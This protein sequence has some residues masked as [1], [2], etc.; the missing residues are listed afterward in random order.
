MLQQNGNVSLTT[1]FNNYSAEV[2]H[3]NMAFPSMITPKLLFV[4]RLQRANCFLY[5]KDIPLA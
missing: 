4:F 1:D 5:S 3:P 2:P